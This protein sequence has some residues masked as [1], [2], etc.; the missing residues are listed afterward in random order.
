[1]LGNSDQGSIN[2][3]HLTHSIKNELDHLTLTDNQLDEDT[4]DFL[5]IGIASELWIFT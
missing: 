2:F 3:S 5:A 4:D 1:M